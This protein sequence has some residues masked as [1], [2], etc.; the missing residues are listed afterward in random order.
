MLKVANKRVVTVILAAMTALMVVGG[1][2][3]SGS[4]VDADKVFD[5]NQKNEKAMKPPGK[6]T[7]IAPPK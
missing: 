6:M 5:E 4:N 7:P 1:C 2:S 3:N